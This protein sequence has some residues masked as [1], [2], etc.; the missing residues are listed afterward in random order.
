MHADIKDTRVSIETMVYATARS[1]TRS[2]P[3]RNLRSMAANFL[4]DSVSICGSIKVVD[5][6]SIPPSER[7]E[8]LATLE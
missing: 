4:P 3:A 8:V 7:Y 5:L 6:N 2:G 1:A